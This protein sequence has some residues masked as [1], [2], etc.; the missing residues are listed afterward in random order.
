LKTLILI[1]GAAGTGK[2]DLVK[3]LCKTQ[4][5]NIKLIKKF[6]TRE[7]RENEIDTDLIFHSSNQKTFDER[8]RDDTFLWYGY[9]NTQETYYGIYKKD[10][11]NIF[12][13]YDY[14]IMIVRSHS[15]IM[16]IKKIFKHINCYS[17]FVYTD[18]SLVEK[19]LKDDG[20]SKS[21][22]KFRLTRI[23]LAW[24]DYLKY[25]HLY[26]DKI[27]N[28]SSTSEYEI[29][30]ENLFTKLKFENKNNL[31]V[32]KDKELPLV[33]PLIG[34]KESMNERLRKYPYN[35][36]IFL[37]MKFRNNN[38]KVYKFIL[39]IIEGKG[40]NCVRADNPE[41]DI[42]RN[43]YNP[44]AV[45]YCCKF[46]IALFDE[47][48]PKNEYSPNVAYE[49]GIMHNQLKECLIVRH[50]NLVPAPFD[51][52]K[53]LYNNYSDNLELEEMIKEWIGK[54]PRLN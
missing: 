44:I 17:V 30:I 33:K 1:D 12:E 10:I 38:S 6:T 18:E 32:E 14:A 48:E 43:T 15:L 7:Q 34:F 49:L 41:W 40:Y 46:G 9:G 13:K 26:D 35:K 16:D 8:Q 47:P 54:L 22:I 5:R 51:L 4:N 11:D 53:E 2:S 42:T 25:S 21:Q 19:R 39:K 24:N 28:S 31:I 36:N 23:P 50:T 52:V 37:M 45:S 3:Y 20:Y 29:L 27:I